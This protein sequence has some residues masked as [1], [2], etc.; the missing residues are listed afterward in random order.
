MKKKIISRKKWNEKKRHGYASISSGNWGLP[1]GTKT[2]LEMD[3][4][5]GGTVLVPVSIRKKRR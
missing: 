3:K 1:K 2:I 5:T 4:K